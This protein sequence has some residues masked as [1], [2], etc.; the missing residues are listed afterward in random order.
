MTRGR[1]VGIPKFRA[2]DRT[3]CFRDA[4]AATGFLVM[5]THPPER[6]LVTSDQ[7]LVAEA[8]AAALADR[9]YLV[10][11][12]PW[13]E[14]TRRTT[15]AEVGLLLSDLERPPRTRRALAVL[16]ATPLPWLVLTAAEHGPVW[17]GLLQE[18][19]RLVGPST[20]TL[21]ELE[22]M[23]SRV[24]ARPGH[25]RGR[26]APPDRRVAPARGR[27][28]RPR[29]ADRDDDSAGAGGAR[30][31]VRRH[32]GAQHRPPPPPVGGHR[33]QPGATG[34]PQARGPH[35]ARRGGGPQRR[36]PAGRRGAR[37]PDRRHPRPVPKV[38]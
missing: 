4:C 3:A 17:G 1:A 21:D 14:A 5:R 18:G 35:P 23:L 28:G 34:A 15:D 12:W 27:A 29:G 30:P 38:G 36:E 9:G 33:P 24:A 7:D 6:V 22:P 20:T 19:A 13:S 32:A 16:H 31:P 11:R 8:I 26:T 2:P 25:S 37:E 10:T